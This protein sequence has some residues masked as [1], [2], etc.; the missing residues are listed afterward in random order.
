MYANNWDKAISAT[1]SDNWQDDMLRN[2]SGILCAYKKD[3]TQID[4]R[5][6]EARNWVDLT[7]MTSQAIAK[8]LPGI[9]NEG[10]DSLS[11]DDDRSDEELTSSMTTRA[12][13]MD[14][15]TDF[16]ACGESRMLYG[17]TT[18]SAAASA[19]LEA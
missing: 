18:T 4:V 8:R 3:Q 12:F 7:C 10:T 11:H 14:N 15:P 6:E 1:G 5:I 16:R 19:C 13:L 2:V 17:I 9:E